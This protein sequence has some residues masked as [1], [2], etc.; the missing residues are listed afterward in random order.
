LTILSSVLDKVKRMTSSSSGRDHAQLNPLT[1]RTQPIGDLMRLAQQRLVGYLDAAL[2]AAGYTDVRSAHV[3]VLAMIEADGSRLMDLADRGARTKQATAE[4]CAHLVARG[5]L[6]LTPDTTD[7]RA[8]LYR[9][10]ESGWV[11]LHAAALAVD[12]YEAWLDRTIGQDAIGQLTRIL[13]TI[14]DKSAG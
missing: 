4:L 12:E 2:S 13:T 7:R 9:P 14:I 11:L 3:S 1:G 10:A 5:D 6:T 8:R